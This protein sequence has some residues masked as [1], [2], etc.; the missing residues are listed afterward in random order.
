MSANLL[1]A[2]SRNRS[3]LLVVSIGVFV[4]ALDQTVVVTALPEMIKD[5]RVPIT[6]LDDAAWIVDGYLLGYAASLPL[7]GRLSDVRGRRVV[8]FGCFGLFLLGSVAV[9]LAPGLWWLV[10]ARLV[11]AIGGGGLLPVGLALAV[12]D[13]DG[14]AWIVLLGIVGAVAEA[15]AVLGPLY[16]GVITNWLGWRWIFWIHIPLVA[17]LSLATWWSLRSYKSPASRERVDWLGAAW[18]AIGLGVLIVGLS[19]IASRHPRVPVPPAWLVVAGLVLLAAYAVVA[20]R[21]D[22]PVVD[23]HLF[24]RVG[25]AAASVVSIL[26]GV[27][28]IIVMVDVPLLANAVFKRTALES[29]LMLMR[30][31]VFLPIGG[32]IGGFAAR[33][34]GNRPTGAVGLALIALGLFSVSMWPASVDDLRITRD[35]AFAG[36]GF[37]LLLAPVVGSAVAAV[38]PKHAGT[39]T[40]LT[41]VSRVIGMMVGLSVL[42]SWGLA[43]FQAAMAEVPLPLPRLDEAA[44]L[45]QQR[46][47]EYQDILEA[48]IWGIYRDT[49]FAAAVVTLVALVPLL[50]M[51]V[52]T[53]SR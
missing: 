47:A 12:D 11:Q 7:I 26:I 45:Y 39:A 23:V 29:G 30:F 31:S 42:T 50:A 33:R 13:S 28:F 41:H 5:L 25:F 4:G 36:F 16:G 3:A 14:R 48:A 35:L 18:I 9:A 24:K 40:A 32:V 19:Q 1:G 15:G 22:S 38:G 8:L 20:Y 27:A 53:P 10:A 44:E 46:V 21:W 17:A 52:K 43:R 6:R 51:R 34:F 37:G 2:S 49:F